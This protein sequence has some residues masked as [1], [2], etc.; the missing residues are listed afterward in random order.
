[1]E[2]LDRSGAVIEL[3]KRIVAQLKLGDDLLSQWMAHLVAERMDAV[4]HA[5]PEV[6]TSAQDVCAETIFQL[7]DHRNSLPDHVRPFR[8][9]EP[10]LE[11]LASLNIESSHRFR[12]LSMPPDQN[13][14]DAAGDSGKSALT[15]AVNLDGA[16]RVLIQYFLAEASKGAADAVRPWLEA[17][18]DA[19][20]DVA[21][22]LQVVEFV[23]A[24]I[25]GAGDN[26]VARNTLEEKVK[27]LQVFADLARAVASDLQSRLNQ[28]A[29]GE[30]SAPT[31]DGE[32]NH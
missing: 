4:E 24:G 18:I 20:A 3:G 29:G 32:P 5:L 8:A 14:P 6:R 10:L 28:R 16:A 26:E 21:L 7:W 25:P 23:S 27:K 22:E 15:L 1:M 30:G 12:F 17:A 13:E 11:T 2:S 9:L 31:T 19:E